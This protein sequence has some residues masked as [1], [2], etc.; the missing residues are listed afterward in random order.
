MQLLWTQVT[1]CTSPHSSDG[2]AVL[3][4]QLGV[5]YLLKSAMFYQDMNTVLLCEMS[6]NHN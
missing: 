6:L 2:D 1:S 5:G 3:S 4:W